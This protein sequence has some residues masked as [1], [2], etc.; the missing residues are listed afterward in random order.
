LGHHKFTFLAF[1]LC[2]KN[3]FL[4]FSLLHNLTLPK[5][6]LA[7]DSLIQLYELPASV[8]FRTP[9]IAESCESNENLAN[10]FQ[11][12]FLINAIS[13]QDNDA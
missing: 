3:D 13:T 1:F 9:D 5:N 4:S 11:L 6:R 10:F 8:R 2:G 12:L 7:G